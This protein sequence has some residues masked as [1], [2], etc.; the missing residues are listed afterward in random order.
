MTTEKKKRILKP[1]KTAD[2]ILLLKILPLIE[3][4]PDFLS[5]E[6][7]FAY[8]DKLSIDLLSFPS[9]SFENAKQVF[10]NIRTIIQETSGIQCKEEAVDSVLNWLIA[11]KHNHRQQ[12][13][14]HKYRYSL[15]SGIGIVKQNRYP[16][17]Q[18]RLVDDPLTEKDIM[19]AVS[20][21]F[22]NGP[23]KFFIGACPRCKKIFEKKQSNSI[24]CGKYCATE[25]TRKKKYINY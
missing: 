22:E 10:R 18:G 16:P 1:K 7:F 9:P 20:N 14:P 5:D 11:S 17:P 21:A 19:E 6:D 4:D 8:A 2:V 15:S 24:F 25:G 13:D 12:P 23:G 3:R